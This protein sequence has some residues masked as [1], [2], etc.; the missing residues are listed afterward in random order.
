MVPYRFTVDVDGGDWGGRKDDHKGLRDGLGLILTTLRMYKIKALFF[1][2]TELLR[3]YKKEIKQILEEGH[4]VGSHGHF[5]I[6][7]KDKWRAEKD[8]QISDTLLLSVTGNPKHKYRAP[9]F[10]YVT[11][12]VYSSPKNHVSLLKHMWLGQKVRKE[13]I[14]YLH[15]FD[16]V[17]GDSPPNLFCRIWYSN[18]QRAYETLLNL[19]NSYT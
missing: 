2:S 7:Y 4:E 18:P 11:E 16:L 19:L 9:K 8:R 17:R 5:H 10:S 3:D 12:D 1:V 6:R 14:I 15:P 13:S